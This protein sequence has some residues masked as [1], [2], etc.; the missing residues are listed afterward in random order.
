MGGQLSRLET[1]NSV[2]CL[3]G[4]IQWSG[5]G[6]ANTVRVKASALALSV[7]RLMRE[8]PLT[9]NMVAIVDDADYEWLMQWKWSAHWKKSTRSFAAVRNEGGRTVAMHREILGLK[10]GDPIQGD[11]DN[12]DT[13]DNRRQN[14]RR[15]NHRQQGFNRRRHRD[16]GSEFKGVRFH[17][18]TGKYMARIAH[19][20]KELYLGQRD[21]AKAAYEE[22]YVPA[23]LKYHGEFACLN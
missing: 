2:E 1:L 21:T 6:P 4:R 16:S 20:G 5:K 10:F 17:K 18:H 23:A 12:H 7:W 9:R 14:L 11:H 22:L 8:I 19:G 3:D 15:A 13:L